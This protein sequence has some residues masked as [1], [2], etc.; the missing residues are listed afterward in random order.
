M[1]TSAV[2][3]ALRQQ[4]ERP[5]SPSATGWLSSGK[6]GWTKQAIDRQRLN[7]E[8]GGSVVDVDGDG[9]LDILGKPHGFG[10]PIMNL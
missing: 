8:A 4:A 6:D 1:N 9:L 5:D 7:I 2:L 10:T 3:A